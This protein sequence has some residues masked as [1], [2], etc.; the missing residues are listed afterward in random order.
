MIEPGK[1]N[2]VDFKR[3]LKIPERVWKER[4]Q[5]LYDHLEKFFDYKIVWEGRCVYIYIYQ[6]YSEYKQIPSKKDAEK[7]TEYYE[8]ETRRIVKEQPFNTGTN[9]ARN[10]IADDHNIYEHQIDTIAR[11]VRPI[12]REK[13][14]AP[15]MHSEWRRLSNDK[16]SY[17]E[18]TEEQK[19]FL[20]SLFA[21]NSK[22]AQLAREIDL[23]AEYKS[24]YI[25]E[26]ELKTQLFNNV[27]ESYEALMSRFKAKFGF[28]PQKV[29]Y[30]QEMVHF[31]K[32]PN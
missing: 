27:A 25:S 23:F 4:R 1:Y 2:L 10:I 7:I 19:E 21:A 13:Y 17:I 29:K 26:E 5:D 20:Y 22:E 18:L 8:G 32:E 28:R 31:N 9:I 14:T 11:Y 15:I 3:I 12:I 30:L 6:Q 24:G 16:L